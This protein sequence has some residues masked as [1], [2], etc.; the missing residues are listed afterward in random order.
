M[1]QPSIGA[2][3]PLELCESAELAAN[4]TL[5]FRSGAQHKE[6]CSLSN[7]QA[8]RTLPAKLLGECARC[9]AGDVHTF[10]PAALPH[11][12]PRTRGASCDALGQNEGGLLPLRR[13]H[14]RIRGLLNRQSFSACACTAIGDG[15][16]RNL[17][18]RNFTRG[19]KLLRNICAI[20]GAPF[21]LHIDPS[22]FGAVAGSGAN[23]LVLKATLNGSQVV[24][25][26]RAPHSWSAEHV[27]DDDDAQQQQCRSSLGGSSLQQMLALQGIPGWPQLFGAACCAYRTASGRTLQLAVDVR[28]ALVAGEFVPTT[29]DSLVRSAALL[30]GLTEGPHHLRLS[31]HIAVGKACQDFFLGAALGGV[32]LRVDKPS[33]STRSGQFC[34]TGSPHGLAVCDTDHMHEISISISAPLPDAATTRS[35]SMP[36]ATYFE[37]M[38]TPG[39]RLE[40]VRDLPLAFINS[41]VRP[42]AASSRAAPGLRHALN[43]LAREVHERHDALVSRR[44]GGVVQ[45]SFSCI[46]AWLRALCVARADQQEQ[47]QRGSSGSLPEC[48]A[49]DAE[50]ATGRGIAARGVPRT[51][52]GGRSECGTDRAR[53]PGD[54]LKRFR[55]D[56]VSMCP[57]WPHTVI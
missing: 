30:Q 34:A 16:P 12:P 37:A 48:V 19:L 23:H 27:L 41:V 2:P 3:C 9:G 4:C 25:R 53:E 29:V 45:L 20:D 42:F 44:A 22:T 57:M 51:G 43:A 7:R 46:G 26:L 32:C 1:H 54:E 6:A 28:Q 17:A 55:A 33:A 40:R 10:L 13:H 52:R 56:S 21:D 24:A 31:E 47:Q 8:A 18:G 5:W 11:F 35:W 39:A 49:E 14:D 36:M 38:Q 50:L 15:V